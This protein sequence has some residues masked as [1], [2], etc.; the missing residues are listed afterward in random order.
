MKLLDQIPTYDEAKLAALDQT[1][2]R[3]FASGN[4]TQKADAEIVRSAIEVE[5]T[6]RRDEAAQRRAELAEKVKDKGLFDR[7]LLAFTE[8][9]LTESEITVLKEVAIRPGRDFNLIAR[10]VGYRDGG[11]INL[12]VGKLCAARVAYLGGAPAATTRKGETAFAPL[13][14]DFT[15]HVEN[16]GTEWHGWTLKPEADAALRHLGIVG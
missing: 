1:A 11:A 2:K 16:D 4:A 5:R 14:I 3:W 13:L 10:A 8:M 7:V 6:R 9:P 12:V 15:R